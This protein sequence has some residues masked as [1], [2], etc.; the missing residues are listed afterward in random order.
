M[1]PET[2]VLAEARRSYTSLS[3]FGYRV[4][5]VVANRIFPADDADDWRA[6]WVMAQDAVLAEVDQSFAGLPIWRSEYRSG[7]A[8]RGGGAGRAGRGP[9]RRLRPARGTAAVPDRSG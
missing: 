6:G 4:D 9:V 3:L 5:G 8:G 7:G 2:V 1:T